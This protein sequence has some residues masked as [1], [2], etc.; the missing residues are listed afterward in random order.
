MRQVSRMALVA[1]V[2]LAPLHLP[3]QARRKVRPVSDS[4]AIRQ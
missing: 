4:I 2:M 1:S 3:A